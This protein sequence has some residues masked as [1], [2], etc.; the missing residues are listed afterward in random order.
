MINRENIFQECNQIVDI[1]S[2][3][4]HENFEVFTEG[5]R[6]K[7]LRVCPPDS[8]Y[9]F[10]LPNHKYLFKEA[11]KSAKDSSKPRHPDQYWAEVI[12][13]HIG[14]LMQLEVPPAF[15]AINSE[16]GEP[17]S[18]IEWFTGYTDVEERSSPG[19][20]HMQSMIPDY[21]REKGR[22]HNLL[23]ILKFSRA[24]AIGK[25]LT[26]DWREYWGLCLCFD[27]LIGNTDRHQEN[28]RVIWNPDGTARLSPYFDN[29]TSLGHE[30]F[31][32]FSSYIRDQNRLNAYVRR[33]R[34]HM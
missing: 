31:P 11:I 27:A 17:G 15:I 25:R 28:W 12:A 13:F 5:A 26:H 30:I 23:D 16:T 1:A 8:G 19:G 14:R 4:V 2:W 24:M 34:H 33:G 6:N 7:S 10:C 32:P 3:P 21:D 29:G 22:K 18:L 9:D 20:D